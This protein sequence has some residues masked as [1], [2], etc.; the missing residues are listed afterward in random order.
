[1]V[2]KIILRFRN[3]SDR[4]QYDILKWLD[5]SSELLPNELNNYELFVH[6]GGVNNKMEKVNEI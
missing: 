3:L 6:K 5:N 1:M 4:Q 2:T